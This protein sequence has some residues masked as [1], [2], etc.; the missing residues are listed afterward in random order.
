MMALR[1]ERSLPLAAGR[2][3]VHG[4]EQRR[5][6]GFRAGMPVSRCERDWQLN[7]AALTG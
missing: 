7:P 6:A 2:G 3:R 5:A 1:G 4:L